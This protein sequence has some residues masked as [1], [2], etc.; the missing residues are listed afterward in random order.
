MTE[1][2]MRDAYILG[3]V[4]A[5]ALVAWVIAPTSFVAQVAYLAFVGEM[6]Y[7]VVKLIGSRR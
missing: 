5:V 4:M 1:P 3:A 7:A 2:T 6:A